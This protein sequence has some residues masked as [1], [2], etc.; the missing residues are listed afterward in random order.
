MRRA[1]ADTEEW[2]QRGP[3]VYTIKDVLVGQMASAEAAEQTVLRHNQFLPVCNL[4]VELAKKV[5]DCRV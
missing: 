3:N 4:V 5:K 2:L 1:S